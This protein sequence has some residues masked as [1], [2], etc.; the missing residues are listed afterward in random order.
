ML[1]GGLIFV[2]VFRFFFFFPFF[3]NQRGFLFLSLSPSSSNSALRNF[4]QVMEP[5]ARRVIR[6]FAKDS[7][8]KIIVVAISETHAVHDA[9]TLLAAE[10]AIQDELYADEQGRELTAPRV[11]PYILRTTE[12]YRTTITK[13][14]FGTESKSIC[15]FGSTWGNPK[16]VLPGKPRLTFEADF[17]I[18]DG[19][20]EWAKWRKDLMNREVTSATSSTSS[21]SSG[22][23][24]AEPITASDMEAARKFWAMEAGAEAAYQSPDMFGVSAEMPSDSADTSTD[25]LDGNAG[26]EIP[27]Y[28]MDIFNVKLFEEDKDLQPLLNIHFTCDNPDERIIRARTL[29]R[30]H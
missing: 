6:E 5:N 30:Q 4:R 23:S 16:Y 21:T 28:I 12:K 15:L 14:H 25:V 29:N 17:L 11:Y 7:S 20:R 8:R 9:A 19:S 27:P 18:P 10:I 3:P 2:R 22:S 26:I 24:S 1:K 13:T